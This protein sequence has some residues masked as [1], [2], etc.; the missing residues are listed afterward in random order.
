MPIAYKNQNLKVF[1]GIRII[2]RGN[3]KSEFLKRYYVFDCCRNILC[4]LW[5][6]TAS[7]RHQFCKLYI[8]NFIKCFLS[9]SFCT[10]ISNNMDIQSLNIIIIK[11]WRNKYDL[12][13]I[14]T[15]FRFLYLYW[16][17]LNKGLLY[18]AN[19]Q[20]HKSW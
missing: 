16:R 2:T 11:L 9:Y 7:V 6:S 20:M 19:V 18:V 4:T 3:L 15:Y 5:N 1:P 14:F 12:K 13:N 17:L 8:F 10:D